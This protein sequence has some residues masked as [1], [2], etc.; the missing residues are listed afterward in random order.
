MEA[1]LLEASESGKQ[2]RKHSLTNEDTSP[3][4]KIKQAN[5]QE[6]AK[7]IPATRPPLKCSDFVVT[8]LENYYKSN[9]PFRLPTEV[10]CFSF[11]EEG[12]QVLGRGGLRSYSQP[13]RLGLDLNVG[14][15][16]YQPKA[17]TNVADLAQLLT[18]ISYKWDV[19]L[20]KLQN[21]K[22]IDFNDVNTAALPIATTRTLTNDPPTKYVTINRSDVS[23]P[24]YYI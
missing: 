4:K 8:N 19:F 15:D 21:Q 3:A 14:Y 11:D 2:P 5:D 1:D 12:R 7:P 6:A 10:G 20:V 9:P 18:W 17:K 16:G 24:C 23:Q 22:S 13:S